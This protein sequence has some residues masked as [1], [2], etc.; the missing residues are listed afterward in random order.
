MWAI[1]ALYFSIHLPMFGPFPSPFQWNGKQSMAGE[2]KC[3][4]VQ[5]LTFGYLGAIGRSG[6]K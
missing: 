2:I 1:C 6:S 4:E 3:N 5:I